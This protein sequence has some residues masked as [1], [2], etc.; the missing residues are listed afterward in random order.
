MFVYIHRGWAR[1][2]SN[3]VQL[4]IR[5]N[6]FYELRDLNGADSLGR[7]DVAIRLP[8][9]VV[10]A[11]RTRGESVWTPKTVEV[12]AATVRRPSSPRRGYALLRDCLTPDGIDR[13]VLGLRTIEG[14]AVVRARLASDPS[15]R[16]SFILGWHLLLVTDYLKRL[17][18]TFA[19][20]VWTLD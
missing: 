18:P 19:R 9:T 5:R 2:A 12:T 20:S 8:E 3:D 4:R 15:E 1:N 11:L 17:R 6:W 14:V 16:R 7:R 13:E 10:D